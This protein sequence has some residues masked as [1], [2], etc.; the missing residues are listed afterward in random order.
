MA[1]RH[2]APLVSERV[3][4]RLL[5]EADLTTTLA[6]R[7]QDGIRKWLF[8]SERI[9]PDQHRRWYLQYVDRDDDFVFVIEETQ[10]LKR[11]VGQVALYN[12]NWA[13]RRAE[14]GRLLIGDGAAA[15]KGLAR[16]ATHCLVDAALDG[17]QIDEIYLNVLT[18]NDKAIAAYKATG[19]VV[20]ATTG[21]QLR[22]CKRASTT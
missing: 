1:K 11:P 4:L 9:M 2:I 18:T 10:M 5:E 21:S 15:R 8:D 6:W 13:Q 12:V 16:E 19:F 7:N 14:F 3:R 20:E 17:W 22:M